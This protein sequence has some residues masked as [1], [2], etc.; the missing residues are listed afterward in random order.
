MRSVFLLGCALCAACT[1]S[2]EEVAPK[3]DQLFFPTGVAVAP[4]D[5][6]LF[7]TN[8]N[9]E[10]VYD[11]GSV[12]VID[13]AA[14]DATIAGWTGAGHTIPADCSQDT[15][16]RE[17]LVC[18]EKQFMLTSAGARIGNFATDVGVQ[19]LHDN[20]RLRLI[21]PTRGDPSITW[22]DWDGSKLV[23]T[24]S[25]GS[26]ALCD[27]DHRLSYVHN[28][29]NLFLLPDEPYNVYVD[30]DDDFAIVTHLTSSGITLVDSPRDGN[31]MIADVMLGLFQADPLTGL[32]GTT[33]VAGR[34]PTGPDD[35]VYIASREENRIQT[36]T[37]GT[38]AN[39][40]PKTHPDH[41]KY[42]VPG[43][44]FFDDFVGGSSGF[45]QDTRG[46]TFSE[47]GSRLYT[48]NRTPPSLQVFD[49]SLGPTGFPNNTG[50]AATDLCRDASTATAVDSG[51]GDRVYVT[52]FDTGQVYVVDPSGTGSVEDIIPVGRGPYAVAAARSRN[53]IYVTNYLE[54]TIAVIDTSP[55][56]PMRNRV[57]LRI[58]I[59]KTPG[60]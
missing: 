21:I 56:S 5:S 28:D 14:V 1:A 10:L 54:D 13:L 24:K 25:G 53:R 35:I 43:D 15:D 2:A 40:D 58:G 30:S 16:H 41:S 9:S 4:G 59:P 20:G 27:E 26:N 48:I 52:C 23:C 36:V 51:D 47:D 55:T 33:G 32:F 49:T 34:G 38:P 50:I 11:S 39:Y 29:P 42:I 3:T 22:M 57:V 6:L 7:V 44:F 8:A 60:T 31:A 45:S 12:S 18:D 19:D 17:T 46:I 37:V